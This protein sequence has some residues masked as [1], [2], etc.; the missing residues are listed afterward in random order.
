MPPCWAIFQ[1]K[2]WVAQ[3]LAELGGRVRDV[4]AEYMLWL[5]EEQLVFGEPGS[6]AMEVADHVFKQ[7][8]GSDGRGLLRGIG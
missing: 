5:G 4:E 3:Y 7:M 8:E 1:N 6:R 2:A